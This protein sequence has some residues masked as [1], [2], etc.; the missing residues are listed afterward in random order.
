LLVRQLPQ[1]EGQW[2]ERLVGLGERWRVQRRVQPRLVPLVRL[3]LISE[4]LSVMVLKQ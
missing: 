3:V 2:Q 4:K 1:V